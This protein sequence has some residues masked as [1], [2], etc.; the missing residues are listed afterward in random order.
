VQVTL[1]DKLA[2]A[3]M[4]KLNEQDMGRVIHMALSGWAN[5]LGLLAPLVDDATVKVAGTPLPAEVAHDAAEQF[6]L[7]AKQAGL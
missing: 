7:A 2:Q 6:A 3:L 1:D 5:E 4:T